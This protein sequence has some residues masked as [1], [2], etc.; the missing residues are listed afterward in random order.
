M[1]NPPGI[2]TAYR[3]W[4]EFKGVTEAA[5]SECSGL[6]AETEI[7]EWEEGGWNAHKHRLLGRRKY[8]NIVLKRGIATKELL[9]WYHKYQVGQEYK[10]LELSIILYGYTG[11]PELRWNVVGALPVK[12][13]GPTFKS[14]STEVA[15]ETFELA[16]HGLDIAK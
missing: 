14:G 8:S 10:R 11:N 7:F 4:V 1:S 15:V 16:H 3:F 12:W 5:F 13:V 2:Y 6:Q 9:D